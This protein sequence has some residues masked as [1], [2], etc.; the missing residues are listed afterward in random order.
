M[1]SGKVPELSMFTDFLKTV[2]LLRPKLVQG[3]MYHG[4]LAAL[5]ATYSY[6]R[7]RPA[8]VWNIRQSVYDLGQEKSLTKKVIYGCSR[9]SCLTDSM[10]Y[11]SRL[12]AWQQIY[13]L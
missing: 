5:A 10:I 1:Q 2:W 7:S 11:N 4:N 3:W 6:P 13:W 8:L 9:L 12:S